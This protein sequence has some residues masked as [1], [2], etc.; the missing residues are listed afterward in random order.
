MKKTTEV[1]SEER[2]FLRLCGKRYKDLIRKKIDMTLNDFK[3]IQCVLIALGLHSYE[4]YFSVKL[5]PQFLNIVADEYE[6]SSIYEREYFSRED[7]IYASMDQY[8]RYLHEFWEQMPLESQKK[9]Y[10]EELE[11]ILW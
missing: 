2:K 11:V 1:L 9:K 10:R 7:N 6:K 5:F 4:V 8:K 3:R